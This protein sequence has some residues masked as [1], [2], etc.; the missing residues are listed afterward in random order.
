MHV[1][2]Q[3]NFHLHVDRK[4]LQEIAS[5]VAGESSCYKSQVAFLR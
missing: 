5:E 2:K 3:A 1:Y 4:A